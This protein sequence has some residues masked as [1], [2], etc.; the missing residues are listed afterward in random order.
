[1]IASFVSLLIGLVISLLISNS[2]TKPINE[3]V[4]ALGEVANGNLDI[5]L[6]VSHGDETGT[7]AESAQ[8]LAGTLYSL[9]SDMDYMS[10]EHDRGEIDV[11]IDASKYSG[12]Y[13][14]VA[15]KI[16]YMVVQHI[17]TKKKV[18]GVFNAI[19][20]GNFETNLEKLPGKQAFLN[21]A[22]DTMRDQ[23]MKI[24]NEVNEMIHDAVNGRLSLRIDENRYIGGWREI[25]MGLNKV[26]DAI[27]IPITEID[28]VMIKLSQGEFDTKVSGDY[29]G[30]FKSIQLSINRTID[31]LSKYISEVSEVLAAIADGDLNHTINRE[32][33]GHFA[34]IKNSINHISTSLNHT[35]SEISSAAQQVLVGANEISNSAMSLANGST[36]Q[37]SSVQELT[38][39]IELI[40]SQTRN[41]ADNASDANALADN[42]AKSAEQGNI[43]MQLMLES[44]HQI[45]ESSN[46]ISHIIKNIQDIAFST[47]LLSLNA[48]VEAARAGSHGKGFSVVAEEV[49]S[50]AARSQKSAQETTQIIEDSI[51]KIDVGVAI[52]KTTAESLDTIVQNASE[53]LTLVND[54]ALSSMEQSTAIG[55]VSIGIGQI[56][57]VV[58]DNTAVSEEAAAAAEQLNSQAEVLRQLVAYFR[59]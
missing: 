46:N 36:T 30:D 54:I 25:M 41:N 38:A 55:E 29:K 43:A 24:S 14:T 50:L 13:N 7:L 45:K 4:T 53:V 9:V 6:N 8:N 16:N 37:A 17:K 23:L 35:I 40:N 20:E 57:D 28:A 33:V 34:E 10:D 52:A 39:S 47:N 11:L 32:Y 12:A 18:V 44:M 42:S 26:S 56:A 31:S 19:A 58:Q 2:I 22:V 27:A 51:A 1:M 48:A 3:V 5:N 49:R 21:E 15:D 59:I